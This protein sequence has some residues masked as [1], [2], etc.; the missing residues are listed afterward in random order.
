MKIVKLLILGTFLLFTMP[1]MA[2]QPTGAQSRTA[3]QSSTVADF[4]TQTIGAITPAIMTAFQTL[5]SNSFVNWVSDTGTSGTVFC[6]VS[7][8]CVVSGAWSFASVP[9]IPLGSTINSGGGVL[10]CTTAT[11]GQV[12]CVK[13]DGSTISINGAGVITATTSAATVVTVGTTTVA[14]GT[15]ADVLSNNAGILGNVAIGS[16][17]GMTTTTTASAITLAEPGGRLNRIYNGSMAIWQ[18]GTATFTI[19]TAATCAGTNLS[20][21]M[22]ADGWAVNATGANGTVAQ[23]TLAKPNKTIFGL[24]LIGAASNTDMKARHRIESNDAAAL[25]GAITTVQFNFSQNT[26]GSVAPKISTCLASAL[27]NFATCNVDLAAT[28]LTSCASG[29][30]CLEAYTFTPNNNASNGYEL[31][32]DCGAL[33]AAQSC[34]ISQVDMRATPGVTNNTIPA[35]VG[36]P[37]VLPAA[38]E[39][40]WAQRYYQWLPFNVGISSQ[41]AGFG[42]FAGITFVAQMRATP[43]LF[44]ALVA[45]PNTSQGNANNASNGFA[46]LTPYSASANLTC[47]TSG[48]CEVIGYREGATAEQ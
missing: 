44:G 1:A 47:V 34:T 18:R 8:N 14:A 35:I 22:T 16:T 4:P 21:C 19:T 26:G 38:T 39:L 25:S 48:F 28:A 11:T 24:Q 12:G 45:D 42:I 29:A 40:N 7:A 33:V 41:S 5:V 37:E 15:N 20:A 32:I 46:Q 2:Q 31:D 9:T 17:G 10:N 30:T 3:V 6:L 36:P 23:A 27:D 43:T 13:P